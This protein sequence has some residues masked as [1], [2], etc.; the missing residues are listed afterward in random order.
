MRRTLSAL[1]IFAVGFALLLGAVLAVAVGQFTADPLAPW[2]SM[3]LSAGAIACSILA[4][5]MASSR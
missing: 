2:I 4:M 3:G 5:G 1:Q